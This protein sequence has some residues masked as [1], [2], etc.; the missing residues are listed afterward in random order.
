MLYSGDGHI[1]P[2]LKL[3]PGDRFRV[4]VHYNDGHFI[5][6]HNSNQEMANLTG[7]WLTVKTRAEHLIGKGVRVSHGYVYSVVVPEEEKRDID[8]D[9]HWYHMDTVEIAG[10]YPSIIAAKREELPDI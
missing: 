9:W 6:T 4:K 1:H 2:G 7:E 3:S 10:A 5:N 8:W